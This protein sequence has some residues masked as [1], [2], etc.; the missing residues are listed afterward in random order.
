MNRAARGSRTVPRRYGLRSLELGVSTLFLPVLWLLVSACSSTDTLD[1][2]AD[3]IEAE[4]SGD[5]EA[6][7]A[8]LLKTVRAQPGRHEAHNQL[9]LLAFRE[10]RFEEAVAHFQL[11]V[12]HHPISAIYRRN[13]ALAEAHAGRLSDA[14]ETLEGALKLDPDDPVLLLDRAKLL[15]MA[16]RREEA[17]AELERVE[18]LSPGT[19]EVDTLREA[20]SVP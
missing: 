3:A 10:G 17:L 11:A 13:L 14:E 16:G 8:K 20:W 6:T 4:R 18:R 19:R 2:Y 15:Y 12:T 5:S 7:L 9:G 1:P